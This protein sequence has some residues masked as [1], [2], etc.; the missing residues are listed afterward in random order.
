MQSKT[1]LLVI[2]FLEFAIYFMVKVARRGMVYWTPINGLSGAALCDV[3]RIFMKF[4][5]DWLVI[6]QVR[7]GGMQ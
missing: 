4:L 1:L 5:S 6:V 3:M 2:V 7:N